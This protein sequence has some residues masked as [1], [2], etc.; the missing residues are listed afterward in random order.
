[1]TVTVRRINPNIGAEILGV[2]LRAP[3]SPEEVATIEK[4]LIDHEVIVL[5]KQPI[6]VEDQIRFGRYFGELT[7][8]PF[9]PNMADHPEVIV[10]DNH[11]DNPPQLTDVWHSD[12][13]FREEPP[14]G[15]I[16]RC[17]ITPEIGGDTLFASMTCAYE[18]LSDRM[19]RHIDGLEAVHDFRPFRTL[20]PA[21]S[22]KLREMEDKFPNP[23]HPVVRVHPVSGR[24]ILNVNP[25]FTVRIVGMKE[26][27]SRMLLEFLFAQAQI[28][29]YQLRVRWEPDQIVFWD[30][31]STQ[32][33][34]VHDYWP[35]RRRMERVTIKGDRP[36]GV[37]R[38][39]SV[40]GE[41]KAFLRTEGLAE[42]S[43]EV[44]ARAFER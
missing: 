3:L 16:L 1:M 31:R 18:G 9:S 24:R 23:V 37:P 2:D 15:T 10:L 30:N 27:E 20:F 39:E 41:K 44:A 13:T 43:G 14:M 32:H 12:E 25:N 36:V 42:A 29:E 22:P 5:R 7:V 11:K 28:P 4:A 38:S 6:E 26:S 19:Q 40:G 35:Q 8:H 33:Y 17:R 34:A 21:G